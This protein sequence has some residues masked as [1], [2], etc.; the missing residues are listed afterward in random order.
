MPNPLFYERQRLRASTWDIPRFLRSY[1][2]T[3]AGDL[4]LPRGLLSP[5]TNL[6]TQAGSRL[7]TTDERQPGTAQAVGFRGVRDLWQQSAHDALAGHDLGVLVA[8]PGSGW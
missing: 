3:I 8:P 4:I 7:E 5:L 6:V 1:D 2:E